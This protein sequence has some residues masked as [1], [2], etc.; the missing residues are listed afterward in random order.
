MFVYL[1]IGI[2]VNACSSALLPRQFDYYHKKLMFVWTQQ[3]RTGQTIGNEQ[4]I[5]RKKL[6]LTHLSFITCDFDYTQKV[7]Y[8]TMTIQIYN[9]KIYIF[10]DRN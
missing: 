5:V 8:H 9:E 1:Y 7:I 10:H 6:T 4:D 2:H 3:I